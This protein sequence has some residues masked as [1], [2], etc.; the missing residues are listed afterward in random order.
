LAFGYLAVFAAH[1]DRNTSDRSA[2]V[3]VPE[4]W[5]R[6][7]PAEIG[8]L[9]GLPRTATATASAPS[10]LLRVGRKP[11]ESLCRAHPP[12]RKVLEEVL[13]AR[14]ASLEEAARRDDPAGD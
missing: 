10:L 4:V 13:A 12:A 7:S 9:A 3:S 1:G 2:G 11:L 6:L 5:P 8:A 14:S